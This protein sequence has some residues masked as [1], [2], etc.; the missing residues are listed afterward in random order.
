MPD[1]LQGQ[2]TDGGPQSLA[3]KTDPEVAPLLRRTHQLRRRL[4]RARTD[5]GQKRAPDWTTSEI[6]LLGTMP[7]LDLAT[8]LGRTVAAGGYR[9]GVL[10]TSQ[11]WPNRILCA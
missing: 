5:T 2:D 7:D 11:C 9:R 6:K 3:E 4:R 10:R 8:Q 1:A